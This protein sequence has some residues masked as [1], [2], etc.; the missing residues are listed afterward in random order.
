MYHERIYSNGIENKMY[1]NGSFDVYQFNWT[2]TAGERKKAFGIRRTDRPQDGMIFAHTDYDYVIRIADKYK[3]E[4][5]TDC[6]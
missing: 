2:N 3:N 4:L 5:L 6:K 1:S